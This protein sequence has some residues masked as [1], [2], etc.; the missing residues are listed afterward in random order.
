MAN[1]TGQNEIRN[2]DNA[3]IR[4]RIVVK[5][6]G[7]ASYVTGGDPY[8]A[9]DNGPGIGVLELIPSFNATDGTTM[10]NCWWDKANSKIIWFVS[11]TGVQVANGVDLSS[12]YV[13]VEAVGK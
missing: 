1:V 2:P 12:C 4:R 9:A 11:S 10:Y 5:Y 3:G 7:P 13:W 6:I 8:S